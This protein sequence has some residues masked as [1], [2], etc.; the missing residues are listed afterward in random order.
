VVIAIIGTLVGLL[1]PAVQAA[2]ESARL[3]QCGNNLR[4]WTLGTQNYHEVYG[5]L[6]LGATSWKC[7]Q[8]S[9]VP[10]LW[11]YVEQTNLAK[12]FKYND[13]VTA[14]GNAAY[15]T[16][17]P[18]APASVRI[19]IYYCPSDRPNAYSSPNGTGYMVARLNY[20]TNS[21]VVVRSGTSFRA[22]FNRAWLNPKSDCVGPS[23]VGFDARGYKG[24]EA[25]KFR[26]ITDGLSKTLILSEINLIT[27]DNEN[28][29]DSR[30]SMW[31]GL[32]FDTSVYT[33]NAGHDIVPAGKSCTNLPPFLPCLATGASGQYSQVARSHHPGGV[34][35]A[36]ADGA[37]QFISDSIDTSTWQAIGT[38]SGRESLSP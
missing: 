21:T 7:T 15:A 26:N 14:W 27:T 29:A 11:P 19:P 36:F 32:W 13:Q 33:P 34:Q 4:Q 30:G 28:P 17:V 18:L 20:A 25:T 3:S 1:L 9:W 22:P 16:T 12:R 6:P 35:A 24:P 5:V 8:S 37:V 2:R 31:S 10:I 23:W 38:I